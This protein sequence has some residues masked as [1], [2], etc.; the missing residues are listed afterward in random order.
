VF[1]P[2][3]EYRKSLNTAIVKRTISPVVLFRSEKMFISGKDIMGLGGR[4][5]GD[6]C[7]TCA[8]RA[9]ARTGACIFISAYFHFYRP[10]NFYRSVQSP[11]YACKLD[12]ATPPLARAIKRTVTL[13]SFVNK[14]GQFLFSRVCSRSDHFLPVDSAFAIVCPRAHQRF[15]Y[16]VMAVDIE[17]N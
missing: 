17:L 7:V 4:V 10:G 12:S 6:T 14:S 13:I 11:S 15:Y 5:R 1:L 8:R 16:L 9:N 2:R 3:N